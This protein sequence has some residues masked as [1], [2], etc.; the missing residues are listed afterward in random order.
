MNHICSK[1]FSWVEV[2]GGD[3]NVEANNRENFKT[4][5]CHSELFYSKVTIFT[6][7]FYCTYSFMKSFFKVHSISISHTFPYS[8]INWHTDLLLTNITLR[9]SR[10]CDQKTLNQ[11]LKVVDASCIL[12]LSSL[13]THLTSP[14]TFWYSLNLLPI[15]LPPQS[16]IKDGGERSHA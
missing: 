12:A 4:G 9:M 2:E 15:P 8:V 1:R 11:S 5:Y 14:L 3:Q 10:H 6:V 16:E 7:I 13:F